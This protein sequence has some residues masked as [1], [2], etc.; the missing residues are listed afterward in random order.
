[1]NMQICACQDIE[2]LR[3]QTT[4][5]AVLHAFRAC[6]VRFQKQYDKFQEDA[7]KTWSYAEAGFTAFDTADIYGPSERILGEFRKKWVS[8]HPDG[9]ALQFFTKYVTQD[10]NPH[11]HPRPKPK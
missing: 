5:A 6:H 11:P 2:F 7:P 9:A 1:M 3:A 8:A 10:Q 4:H